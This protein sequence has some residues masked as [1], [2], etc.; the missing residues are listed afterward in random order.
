MEDIDMIIDKLV[1]RAIKFNEDWVINMIMN[2]KEED[3]MFK[4]AC[5]DYELEK[6]NIWKVF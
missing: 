2:E 4:R 5:Q 3:L 6:N 1:K